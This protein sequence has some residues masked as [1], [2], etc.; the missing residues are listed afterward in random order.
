MAMWVLL[1]FTAYLRPREAMELKVKQMIKPNSSV[2]QHW[3][4]LRFPSEQTQVSKVGDQDDS[5]MLDSN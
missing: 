1:S 3:S 4:L 5:V 2:S